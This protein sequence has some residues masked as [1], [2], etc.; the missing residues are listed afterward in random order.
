MHQST[1]APTPTGQRAPI[2]LWQNTTSCVCVISGGKTNKQTN[3]KL[4]ICIDP[5]DLKKK[6]INKMWAQHEERCRIVILAK[7]MRKVQNIALWTHLV[8]HAGFSNTIWHNHS[9]SDFFYCAIYSAHNQ[10]LSD[11][12]KH[13]TEKI[14]VIAN[15]AAFLGFKDVSWEQINKR[16][17]ID[18][19]IQRDR[20][21]GKGEGC[22]YVK[23]QCIFV[24][25][26]IRYRVL[27]NLKE[28][29]NFNLFSCRNLDKRRELQNS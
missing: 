22:S 4:Q 29:E 25:Q 24:K 1:L 13:K 18:H 6:N 8:A 27:G 26:E 14:K 3:K 10:L 2:A 23:Q 7:W 28:L 19:N 9:F 11:Q 20:E 16:L 21:Q 12:G 17:E 15:A 5:V